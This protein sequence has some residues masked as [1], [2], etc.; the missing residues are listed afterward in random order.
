MC[1]CDDDS[2][3]QHLVG[4]RLVDVMVLEESF[5]AEIKRSVILFLKH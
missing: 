5:M 2:Q 1:C 3:E 4:K